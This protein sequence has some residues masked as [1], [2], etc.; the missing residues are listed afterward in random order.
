MD[1]VSVAQCALNLA[2][3]SESGVS[4]SVLGM[5]DFFDPLH[6]LVINE[7]SLMTNETAGLTK[8]MGEICPAKI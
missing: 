4:H 2:F 1:I 5:S 8:A 7:I 6:C 3:S